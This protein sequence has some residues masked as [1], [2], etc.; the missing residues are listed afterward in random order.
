VV[1]HCS[2][3]ED[4]SPKAGASYFSS[5]GMDIHEVLHVEMFV[6]QSS[7]MPSSGVRRKL[8]WGVHSVAY[9]GHLYL[10]CDFCDVTI[11]RHIHVFKRSLLT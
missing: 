1:Q 6:E 3:A 5:G 7:A 9:G 11:R 2:V 4:R 8:L 10:V